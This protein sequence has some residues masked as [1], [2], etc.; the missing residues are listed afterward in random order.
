ML[1][2]KQC[3]SNIVKGYRLEERQ[4]VRKLE[5][6]Q[7]L[8]FGDGDFVFFSVIKTKSNITSHFVWRSRNQTSRISKEN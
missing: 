3:V 8:S 2:V 6:Q 7:A 1:A 4:A 5:A